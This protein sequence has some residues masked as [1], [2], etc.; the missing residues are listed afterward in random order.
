MKIRLLVIGKTTPEYLF[1]GVEDYVARIKHYIGFD[2]ETLP[3]VKRSQGMSPERLCELEADSFL[4]RIKSNEFVVLL[5]ERGSA[6]DS[7]KMA[8]TVEKWMNTGVVNPVF[9]IGGAYGFGSELRKRSNAVW[10]LSALTFSHQMVR[11]I[12]IE[13]LYRSFTIIKGEP[14]HHK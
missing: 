5:D 2:L 11:L 1:K 9:V 6:C 8:Q 12:F 13:Q 4:K 14:Y 7:I 10:S 3:D